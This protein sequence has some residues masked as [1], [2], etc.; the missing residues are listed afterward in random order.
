MLQS[1]NQR[2]SSV[3]EG[4]TFIWGTA[5]LLLYS[6][7]LKTDYHSLNYIAGLRNCYSNTWCPGIQCVLNW[8]KL[9]DG[10]LLTFLLFLWETLIPR[11]D[12]QE[13]DKEERHRD[14]KKKHSL[15]NVTLY[16]ITQILQFL[17]WLSTWNLRVKQFCPTSTSLYFW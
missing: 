1:I 15:M 17:I 11:E 5:A 14:D 13:E 4:T 6:V 10:H 12:R 2:P 8:R 7:S 16:L 9:Q 3:G